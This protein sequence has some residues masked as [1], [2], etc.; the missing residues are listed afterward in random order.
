MRAF[1]VASEVGVVDAALDRLLAPILGYVLRPWPARLYALVREQA[2]R[3]RMDEP[4]WIRTL[5]T[6]PSDPRL[7]SVL[8]A[9]TVPHTQFFRHA[10]QLH[11]LGEWMRQ[12]A[13]PVRIWCAGCATGEEAWSLA[14]C[15][16]RVGVDARILATDV[17][18]AAIATARAGAYPARRASPE[19]PSFDASR[20]WVAPDR[21]RRGVRFEVA[22]LVSEDPAVGQG[23]FDAVC[24]RNVLIYFTHPAATALLAKLARHVTSDGVVIVAPVEV[25]VPP[26][27]VLESALPLGWLRRVTPARRSIAPRPSRAPARP[28]LHR[29]P[30]A[31]AIRTSARPSSPP[32]PPGLERAARFLGSGELHSAEDALRELLDTSPHDARAWFL[33]GETLG[34]RGEKTQAKHAYARA[35]R[36]AESHLVPD[37]DATTL[38]EAARRR[39]DSL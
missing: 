6:T 31:R 38:A 39:A 24:C 2:E 28:S 22:S 19:L 13:R 37:V 8:D 26:P 16:E 34:A 15:A 32:P 5:A 18:A 29:Q 4:A 12:R 23:P 21:L 30:L 27:A 14:I 7:A 3:A 20:G 9:A 33:L 36:A 35:A 11:A 25:L 10:E 1:G 17:S